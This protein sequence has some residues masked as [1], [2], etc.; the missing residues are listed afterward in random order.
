MQSRMR[1]AFTL[2]EIMVGL[3]VAAAVLFPLVALHASRVMKGEGLDVDTE[4]VT[5]AGNAMEALLS[6]NLPFRS[7]K[8]AGNGNPSA[9]GLTKSVGGVGQAGFD[10][11]E[12]ERLISD[13][14]EGADRVKV[15]PKGILFRVYFFAGAYYDRDNAGCTD[16][17]GGPD[18]G[19]LMPRVREEL[20][21]SHLPGPYGDRAAQ[22]FWTI[23]NAVFQK[24]NNIKILPSTNPVKGIADFTPCPYKLKGFEKTPSDPQGYVLKPASTPWYY[25]DSNNYFRLPGWPTSPVGT[26]R[27]RSGATD[28]RP[29]L[30]TKLYEV[31]SRTG[32]AAG[33]GLPTWGY[34]PITSDLGMF[35]RDDPKCALLK[36]V[37]GVKAHS[38]NFKVSGPTGSSTPEREFWLVSF[39]ARLDDQ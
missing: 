16:P 22:E 12:W 30:Q 18:S 23:D 3:V 17:R 20:T 19:K 11:A 26:Y 37:V 14:F 28:N 15:S 39:K 9:Q 25:T 6:P 7:I 35:I 33:W 21:F 5:V 36:L 2:V 8:P 31:A 27:I 4:A 10:K 34:H 24:A 13:R 32:N 38:Y 1:R 29:A